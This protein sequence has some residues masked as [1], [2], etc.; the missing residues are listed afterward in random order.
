MRRSLVPLLAVV[1]LI[2]IASSKAQD[3]D[4][5]SR[6]PGWWEMQ[7]VITG[8]TPEPIRQT[9]RICTNAEVDKRQSPFGVNM[10]GAVCP[11]PT[12]ARMSDHWMLSGAC[13]T[14]ASKT[15]TDVTATGDFNDRYHSDIAIHVDPPPQPGAAEMHIRVDARWLG[16]CPADKQPGH[17]DFVANPAPA[18]PAGK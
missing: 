14:G 10:N 1:A 2:P 8:P 4:A 15:S 9:Q 6:K 7:F 5:P 17:I 16:E 12:I 18:P 13:Q 3:A 11:A